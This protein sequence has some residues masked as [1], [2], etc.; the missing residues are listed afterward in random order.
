MNSKDS[1]FSSDIA[2]L[3]RVSLTHGPSLD[4]FHSI[5]VMEVPESDGLFVLLFVFI[6]NILKFRDFIL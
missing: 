2:E 5:L 1:E 3:A 6:V 4:A